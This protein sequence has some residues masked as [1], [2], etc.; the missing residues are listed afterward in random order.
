M[1][2]DFSVMS[3]GQMLLLALVVIVPITPNLWAIWH[4]FHRD[5][6]SVNEKMIWLGLA[7]FV[8]V[9]GGLG[10][11]LIGRKRGKKPL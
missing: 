7:V 6:P 10:Y 5:F 2:P 1:I 3:A 4:C 8:P 9:V 11:L